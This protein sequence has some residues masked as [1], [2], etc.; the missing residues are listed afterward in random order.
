M[1][2]DVSQFGILIRENY[3][4]FWGGIFSNWYKSKF[5]INNI[6]YNCVEQYMMWAKAMTFHD[7]ETA[8]LIMSTNDPKKQKEY[9][10]KVRGYI[11]EVWQAIRYETVRNAI[12]AKYDQNPHLQSILL[13]TDPYIICEASPYDLIWGIG[14]A[15]DHKDAVNP[16]K[17]KGTNLLG[18]ATMDV[19]ATLIKMQDD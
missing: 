5:T 2:I 1:S 13:S 3:A 12:F 14:L 8:D 4:L 7:N 17:W 11:E 9:G 18:M 10:R 15:A 16:G 6:E 19:R